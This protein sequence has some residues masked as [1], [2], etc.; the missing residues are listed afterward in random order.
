[1]SHDIHPTLKSIYRVQGI[2]VQLAWLCL[3]AALFFYSP[4]VLAN[5]FI[6][7]LCGLYTYLVL[8]GKRYDLHNQPFNV[9]TFFH[10]KGCIGYVEKYAD[11]FY[12]LDAYFGV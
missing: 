7:V 10:I 4:I 2:L 9:K 11:G 5:A 12:G 8:F 6:L 3:I 1:M